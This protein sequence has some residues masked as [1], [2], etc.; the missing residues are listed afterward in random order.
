MPVMWGMPQGT[1]LSALS[2]QPHTQ[3]NPADFH[4]PGFF[5]LLSL[6]TV[7]RTPTRPTSH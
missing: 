3:K 4:R 7:P 1:S 2:A 6:P 5:F